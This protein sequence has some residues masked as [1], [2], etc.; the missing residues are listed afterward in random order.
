MLLIFSSPLLCNNVAQLP[1]SLSPF[2]PFSFS[3]SLFPPPT[4]PPP[5]LSLPAAMASIT[6]TANSLTAELDAAS[7]LGLVRLLRQSDAQLFAGWSTFAGTS[8]ASC[9][10]ALCALAQHVAHAFA[11]GGHVVLSGSGTSGRMAFLLARAFNLRLA[12]AGRPQ[13]CHYLCAGGDVALFSSREAPEDDW[14]CGRDRLADI[15]E[16]SNGGDSG[17]DSGG[18]NGGPPVVLI[19]ITCGFSAPF[20][21]GQLAYAL[22]SGGRVVP[23]LLGFNPCERARTASIEGWDRSFKAV[24]DAMLAAGAVILNPVVGPEA[25][26]GSTR[27]KGGSATKLLLEIAMGLAW[28]QAFE[29]GATAT[30]TTAAGDTPMPPAPSHAEVREALRRYEIGV[31]HV[32]YQEEALAAAIERVAVSLRAGRHLYYLGRGVFGIEALID[33]SECPPTYNAAF[34]DVRAFLCGGYATLGNDDGDLAAK[35]EPDLQLRWQFFAEHVVPTLTPEDTIVVLDGL[36]AGA[37]GSDD[38]EAPLLPEIC[39]GA[40]ARGAAVVACAVGPEAAQLDLAA[41]T[42]GVA[43][44]AEVRVPLDPA[45]SAL[46]CP[47]DN[48]FVAELAAKLVLNA[49]TTGGF[50]LMGKVMK[51]RMIDLQVGVGGKGERGKERGGAF[52][53]S[54]TGP[55]LYPRATLFFTFLSTR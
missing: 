1:F 14:R 26:T 13:R 29:L 46:L 45:A 38:S 2:L 24:V 39:A 9:V 41:L 32:Y 6:E 7:P 36:G 47:Q 33:A 4:S 20:V 16:R 31:R 22:E 53:A 21:A 27:M 8:D 51:N 49:L 34:D 43:L 55:L 50:V 48:V 10:A 25:L 30:A 5:A 15:V 52:S 42:G 23:V 28:R 40:A 35:G 18:G 12:R 44:A 37:P 19:G 3:L 17:G 11:H 54:T